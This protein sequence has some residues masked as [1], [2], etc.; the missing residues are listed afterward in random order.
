MFKIKM[1]VPGGG[2]RYLEM[3]VIPRVGE[4]IHFAETGG[5]GQLAEN[6]EWVSLVV[7][8]VSYTGA[9]AK[10]MYGE[11]WQI[12]IRTTRHDFDEEESEFLN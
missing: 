8:E 1:F 7:K 12:A 3:P 2:K 6:G 9:E 11:T 5:L 10:R 4:I